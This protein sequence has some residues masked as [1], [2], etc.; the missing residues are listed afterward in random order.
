MVYVSENISPTGAFEDLSGQQLAID[1]LV[2]CFAHSGAAK[3]LIQL[4]ISQQ[5]VHLGHRVLSSG[6]RRG[7]VRP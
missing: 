3:A 5:H 4:G 6:S 1:N 7:V 2:L